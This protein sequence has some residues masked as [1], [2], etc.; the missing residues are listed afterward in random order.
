[1]GVF[2]IRLPRMQPG[3]SERPIQWGREKGTWACTRGM[4]LDLQAGSR[5]TR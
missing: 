1:M 5:W 4:L 2:L 3:F